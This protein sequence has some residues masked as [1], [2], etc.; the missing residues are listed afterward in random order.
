MGVYWF[1]LLGP[2]RSPLLGGLVPF[3]ETMEE[4]RSMTGEG[5]EG[6]GKEGQFADIPEI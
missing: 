3:I 5:H 1:L 6:K 4:G 2:S